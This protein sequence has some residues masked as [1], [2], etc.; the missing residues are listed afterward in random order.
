MRLIVVIKGIIFEFVP[1]IN[2]NEMCKI[3]LTHG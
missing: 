2:K 1:D 3:L